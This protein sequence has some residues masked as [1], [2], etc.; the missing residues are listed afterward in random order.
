VAGVSEREKRPFDA[1]LPPRLLLKPERA[2]VT[3]VLI[4]VGYFR[5]FLYPALVLRG[6]G[7]F[8]ENEP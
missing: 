1:G 8:L 7:H 4:F 3:D 6:A 5:V 2:S